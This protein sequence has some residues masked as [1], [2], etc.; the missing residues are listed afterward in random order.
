MKK[1]FL[2][3][4]I[5]VI[6]MQ[7]SFSQNEIWQTAIYASDDWSY[8]PGSDQIPNNWRGLDFDDSAWE[9]GPGSIGYGD[10][11]DAT[12]VDQLFSLYMRKTFAVSDKD[13]IL[14]S[15]FN[16]D[17]DD[18]Y[19]A[20][21]NG[22]EIAREN[23]LGDF[24][25]WDQNAIGEREA[26]IYSGGEALNYFIDPVLLESI[27]LEG[28]NVLAIQTHN[29]N[30][31]SSSDL[32]TLYWLSFLATEPLPEFGPFHIEGAQT[33]ETTPL[34]I[35]KINTFGAEI[36][37]EP[38]IDAK[39]GIVW[40]DDGSPNDFSAFANEFEGN[41]RIEKRGQSSLFLFPKVSYSFETVNDFG[42]DVDATF[43]NFPE[44]EDFILHG[45]YSDKTLIRNVLI[46][47][48]ANQMGQYATRTRYVELEI[49]GLYEGIYVLMERIKR[50]NDRV[51]IANLREEDISGDELTGGYI[52]KID[53]GE[54]DWFSQYDMENNPGSKLHFQHVYPRR[55]DI[56][57]EQAQ[58]IKSYVDSFERAMVTPELQ[59]DGKFYHEFIDLESFVDH[60]LLVE[61]SKDVDGYR[62]STFM[63]KDKDSNGGK[64]KCGPLWDFNLSFGNADYCNGWTPSE[65]MYYTHCDNGNPFWWDHLIKEPLFK[66]LA[67]CRWQELRQT[68]LNLDNLYE[69][70]DEK[71]EILDPAI[72]RNYNRWPVLG[73]Y[74]WPNYYVPSSY[75]GEI[76]VLKDFISARL[77]WLDNNMF[78]VCDSSSIIDVEHDFDF[79]ISP[80]PTSDF[81]N[82]VFEFSIQGG[83]EFEIY[84]EL[85]RL[86]TDVTAE[87]GERDIQIDVS[88][89]T[90]GIYFIRAESVGDSQTVKK[91]VI[92]K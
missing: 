17:Y 78:G 56:R 37:D 44:E 87:Y 40:N 79:E 85:G 9:T 68:V 34:P 35:V 2:T 61:F 62:F 51:D 76:D 74:V 70:I 48:I 89:L 22:V 83:F 15:L 4:M 84:D 77:F 39:I 42:E 18:S 65:F 86:F 46:F 43:L 45:P 91:F 25:S 10:N 11:D 92:T 5:S 31:L 29:R 72:E 80:N 28:E 36:L 71:V 30:G 73:Q 23:I 64:L 8:I 47:D 59:P 63:H 1:H 52:F 49:N 88:Q 12:I 58:Y 7:Y 50:D 69:L 57:P 20:Y 60:F 67:K 16:A 21:L 24:P 75:L 55:E 32:T 26:A 41:I 82:L 3:L 54:A 90:K 27:L 33:G 81:L 19:V 13:K 38:K 6:S 14:G 66:D 53:K